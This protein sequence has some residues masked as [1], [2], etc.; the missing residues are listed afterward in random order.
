[1]K[2]ILDAEK[3]R[4]ALRTA[5]RKEK[6]ERKRRLEALDQKVTYVSDEEMAKMRAEAQAARDN[7]KRDKALAQA[8]RQQAK[9]D[10]EQDR[11]EALKEKKLVHAGFV[12]TK[13]GDWKIGR[14]AAITAEEALAE[15]AAVKRQRRGYE[16]PVIEDVLNKGGW[17]QSEI[18]PNVWSRPNWEKNEGNCVRTFKQAYKIQLKLNSKES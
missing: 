7:K 12:Q 9:H 8:A 11:L 13:G 6:R 10:K 5:E 18:D 2:M 17:T 16:Q 1:M 14:S 3:Q 15:I 4:K